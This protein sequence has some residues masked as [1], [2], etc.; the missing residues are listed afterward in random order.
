MALDF[1]KPVPGCNF[2]SPV[3]E[4]KQRIK[5]FLEIVSQIC[6][7]LPLRQG[8]ASYFLFL[9]LQSLFLTCPQT[10]EF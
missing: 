10:S 8:E 2:I 5:Q 1:H 4:T 9:V 6:S 3:S 7:K